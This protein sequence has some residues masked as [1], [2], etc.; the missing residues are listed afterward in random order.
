MIS[1]SIE[2][3]SFGI[4]CNS[5]VQCNRSQYCTVVFTLQWQVILIH[6]ML[7]QKL[8]DLVQIFS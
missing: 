4:K 5:T 3:I 2:I 7:E 6:K 8:D 1:K